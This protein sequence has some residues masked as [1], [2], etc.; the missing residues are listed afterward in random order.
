MLGGVISPLLA[1]IYL[2]WFEVVLLR[3]L[4]KERVAA[5]L[6]RYADDF[7]TLAGDLSETLTAFV[8]EKL[9]GWMGLRINREKT[10]C[11]SLMDAGHRLD[12]LGYSLRF[13]RDLYGRPQIYLYV[14]AS[15]KS[16]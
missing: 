10:C 12:F 9:E 2:H 6:V 14:F 1:N 8:E 3:E 4:G 11:F 15:R 13:D 5:G 7:V 16:L